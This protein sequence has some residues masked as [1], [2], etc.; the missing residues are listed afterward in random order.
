MSELALVTG[1][2]GF[3]GSWICRALLAEGFRVRAMH[4]TSSSLTAIHDLPVERVTGDILEPQTLNA[5]MQGV[6]FVFHAAAQ[7]D[8]WRNPQG[9]LETSIEGTR[10]VCEAALTAGVERL[11]LTSSISAMGLPEEGELLD[12]SHTYNLPPGDFPYGYAK[13]R[14]EVAAL[15]VHARG[16]DLVITNPSIVLGPGDINQISGS[17]VIEAERG[18]TFLWVNGGV[19]YI[20]IADAAEGH[21]KALRDG[22]PGE[23]YILGGENLTHREAFS[24]LARIAGGPAPWIQL[25]RALVPFSATL[26]DSLNRFVNMPLNGAQLRMAARHI[27]CDTTKASEDLNFSA[28]RT[29]PQ[30]ALEAYRWYK[31]HGYI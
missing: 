6:Q 30:A 19:N 12:E 15:E 2:T 31:D 8:Y 3:V 17:L 23:R 10:N 4:R 16:L 29:F 24:E 11:V 28:R 21:L 25:P 26:I 27:F 18:R 9:V 7:S 13:R 14:A 22:S 1:A 20:H 5:P